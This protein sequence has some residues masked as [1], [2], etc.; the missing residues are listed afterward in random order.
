MLRVPARKLASDQKS[1]WGGG[2]SWHKWFYRLEPNAGWSSLLPQLVNKEKQVGDLRSSFP[3]PACARTAAAAVLAALTVSHHCLAPGS[4][5]DNANSRAAQLP[6]IPCHG[7]GQAEWVFLAGFWLHW[8]VLLVDTMKVPAEKKIP[9]Y[10]SPFSYIFHYPEPTG[11]WEITVAPL[12][13]QLFLRYAHVSWSH[14]RSR[15]PSKG[16]HHGNTHTE[17]VSYNSVPN[18]LMPPSFLSSPSIP[19][20]FLFLQLPFAIKPPPFFT[21]L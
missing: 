20:S 14:P 7:I 12:S 13:A 11:V 16:G 1:D 9:T 18:I 15:N 6:T 17:T 21:P 5:R 3:N 10:L 2:L 19:G 4:N 8:L